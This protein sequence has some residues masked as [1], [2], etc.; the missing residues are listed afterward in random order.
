MRDFFKQRFSNDIILFI[1]VLCISLSFVQFIASVEI[2][3]TETVF[4]ERR[5]ELY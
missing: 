4:R 1:S 5:F 3:C 2:P